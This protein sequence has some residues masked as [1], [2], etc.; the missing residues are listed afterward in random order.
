[1]QEFLADQVKVTTRESDG[2]VKITFSTGEY[3]RNEAMKVYL[4]A[5]QLIDNGGAVRIKVEAE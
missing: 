2:S 1:M 3:Q 4:L 5:Q